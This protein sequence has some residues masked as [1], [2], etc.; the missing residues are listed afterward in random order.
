[1]GKDS[2]GKWIYKVWLNLSEVCVRVFIYICVRERWEMTPPGDSEDSEGR[3]QGVGGGGGGVVG[4][5]IPHATHM[6]N[7]GFNAG[8]AHG[9][10]RRVRHRQALPGDAA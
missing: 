9:L 7:P 1:M 6:H 10:P 8:G 5:S 3:E 4:A 2:A